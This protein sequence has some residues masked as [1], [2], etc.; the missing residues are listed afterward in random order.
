MKNFPKLRTIDEAASLANANGKSES[1][2]K[3][4][5]D[6]ERCASPEEVL[7]YAE[8]RGL[9]IVDYKFTD[10]LGRWHHFSAPIHHLT[11]GAFDEGIGFDGSSIRAFQ[12]IHESDMILL[13]DPTTAIV[14]PAMEIPTLSLVCNIRDP[15]T[16]EPYSKDSRFIA[17]KAE[18]F[19]AQS[20]IA[21]ISYWG[22]EA[23]FFV[24]DGVRFDYQ[25]G[26]AFFE[27]ESDMAYW[28]NGRG[29]DERF[30]ANLG[31]RPELKR[32]YYRVPPVDTLQDFR[33]EAILRMITSGVDVE[34]HHGEVGSGGQMEIDLKYGSL[35]AMADQIML[36]KYILKNTAVAHHK[37][38]TFMPKP[39]FGDNG[40]G[41][42]CHQSLWK[43]G[44]SL[45]YDADGYAHL[46]EMAHHYIGGIL[47]H[48]PALLAF[49]APTTNS[50]K[51]LVPGYEAPVMMAFSNR[52]RSACIRIPVYSRSP[53][54]VR[55][56]YRC[57]DPAANP[58]LAFAA[59][60]MA[61]IDGIVNK[62]DPGLPMDIDL[63]E[64][65]A[66]EV[67]QV[68]GSL[69]EV[70]SHL[71]DDHEF[72]L[73][74]GVFTEDLIETWIDWKIEHE[75]DPLRLRPHPMEYILY[76]DV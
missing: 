72:L 11:L 33:S 52:N 45:F 65:D 32:G 58:Y 64:Q 63:Y 48:T 6:I 73:R 12:E 61:G 69:S 51:R 57:P 71:A 15:I 19:L 56:E 37:T 67:P 42:H 54:A 44:Q 17:S 28:E 43:D 29:F 75:V 24:F 31:Y 16:G 68:P 30:G 18:Q 47:K 46:S 25:G 35:V 14:D 20:G 62:I 70:L 34:V 10:M 13:P 27:I 8:K 49:C 59:I 4:T 53:E 2:P 5:P 40:N 38:V 22:P 21:D 1:S 55:I 60:L 26:K 23:E 39:M 50:Y 76:Y 3:I 36:Y 66:P 7:L 9:R 41:M 74:G